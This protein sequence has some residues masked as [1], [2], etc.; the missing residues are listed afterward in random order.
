MP[1]PKDYNPYD[2]ADVERFKRDLA[3][4][5]VESYPTKEIECDDC[6]F[7]SRIARIVPLRDAWCPQCRGSN[8][9]LHRDGREL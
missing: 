3:A 7:V 4:G 6:G 9:R 2:L 8:I 5:R 1:T